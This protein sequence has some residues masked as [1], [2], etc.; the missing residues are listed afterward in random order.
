[1]S[2]KQGITEQWVRFNC[3]SSSDF[4]R[5]GFTPPPKINFS[6]RPVG[7]FEIVAPTLERTSTPEILCSYR[8]LCYTKYCVQRQLLSQNCGVKYRRRATLQSSPGSPT[9]FALT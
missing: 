4:W 1:R 5:W 3:L 8:E 2:G 7:A 6:T 9:L